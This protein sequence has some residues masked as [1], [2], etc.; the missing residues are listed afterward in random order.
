MREVIGRIVDLILLPLRLV[1]LVISAP[2]HFLLWFATK[3]WFV[4]I[5]LFSPF[6]NSF[7]PKRI[8]MV[9]CGRKFQT[10]ILIV[11]FYFF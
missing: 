1:A 3:T 2:L 5:P 8:A 7:V 11:I 9:F 10:D 6:Y 4:I